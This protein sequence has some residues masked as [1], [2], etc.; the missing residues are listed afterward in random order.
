M[1]IDIGFCYVKLVFIYETSGG[2]VLCDFKLWLFGGLQRNSG[3]SMQPRQ[4]RGLL[5]PL[6]N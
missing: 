6:A 1:I 2:R 5:V 3:A 4:K